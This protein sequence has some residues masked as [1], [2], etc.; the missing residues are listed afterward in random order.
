MFQKL[1]DH[2]QVIELTFEAFKNAKERRD[3]FSLYLWVIFS[4]VPL[5]LVLG[6][7]V[8]L[9]A[10]RSFFNHIFM[11]LL[12]SPIVLFQWLK[13]GITSFLR[14]WFHKD[15]GKD[16]EFEKSLTLANNIC[17]VMEDFFPFY[18]VPYGGDMEGEM[19]YLLIPSN[20]FKDNSLVNNAEA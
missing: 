13:C 20:I 4:C 15:E 11:C 12:V 9:W 7:N 6:R 10:F 17:V 3:I 18:A 14:S 2:V 8:P 19:Y 16:E 1:M 5:E